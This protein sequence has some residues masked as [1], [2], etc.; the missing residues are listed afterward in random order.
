MPP[1]RGPKSAVPP[2]P[3][4]TDGASSTP[5]AADTAPVLD[6]SKV[7]AGVATLHH[8][9]K[10]L[11]T[12][13]EAIF[14]LLESSSPAE[15]EAME[16]RF[17]TEHGADWVTLRVA[18]ADDL[19]G[20]EL[21]RAL[22]ALDAG[23]PNLTRNADLRDL[24][25]GGGVQGKVREFMTWADWGRGG[26][27]DSVDGIPRVL[28]EEI[29]RDL[30]PE[31]KTGDVILCGNNGGLTH[32]A[33]YVGDGEIIHT[34]ATE[35]TM[36]GTGGRLLDLLSVPVDRARERAGEK[37]RLQGVIREKVDDF[38]ER[39]ERDTYVIMRSDQLDPGKAERGVQ[40]LEELVGKGYDFDFAPGNDAYYCT[41]LVGEF[42]NAGL[43]AQ[44]PRVGSAPVEV[45]LMLHR[46][47]VV[48]P[49]DYLVSPDLKPAL[50]NKAARIHFVD[51]LGAATI[52]GSDD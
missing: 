21:G 29:R 8:A 52:V 11:A 20:A 27:P 4:P 51:Q 23:R 38:F 3:A 35:K 40:R 26:D 33:V 32:S 10:G 24:G 47:A 43:G 19:S 49:K 42:F 50:A 6:A 1:V 17:A 9:M 46:E 36:R 41:E 48:D 30:L 22:K 44:A 31:L 45:P 39:Y 7:D 34:M 25:K 18:L 13:E 5:R 37:P 16:Q 14:K 28:G 15:R 12:D 2:P